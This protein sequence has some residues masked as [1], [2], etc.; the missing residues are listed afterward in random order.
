MRKF[1][2]PKLVIA[3]AV[4]TVLL[5]ALM[6]Y[7]E[8]TKSHGP[9]S[10]T[11]GLVLNPVQRIGYMANIKVEE[12]ID[13]YFHF[14]EVRQENES[15]KQKLAETES[16]IRQFDQIQ[17]ENIELKAMFQF[18]DRHSQY[19]YIGTNVINRSLSP[20]SPSYT[21]D[22]GTKDG[23]RKGMVVI[24]YEG[25]A[26]QI[27]E[28]FD[29]HSLLETISSENV[30]VSVISAG[31]REFEGMLSGTS[32]LG[33]SNMA[34]LTEM[35]LESAIKPGDDIVT[36]GIGGYYPPDIYVG[37]IESVAEDRGK[38]MKTAVVRP[39]VQFNGTEQFYIVLPQNME[40][41]TY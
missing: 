17:K 11:A 1:K 7:S 38:L 21:L 31:S 23:I 27:T 6:A 2:K 34:I 29:H 3:T 22:K 32:I 15:L 36:S 26:G 30:K 35:S 14:Q 39:V 20:L 18:K 24:T 4:I 37:K 25:L 40:D 13:F 9:V 12:F 33:R 28:V 5:C 41:L 10:G 8:L 19:Q 16:K